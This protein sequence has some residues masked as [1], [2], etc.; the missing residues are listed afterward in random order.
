MSK[1][2]RFEINNNNFILING[3]CLEE[4]Y[5]IK[6]NSIDLI[7][8]DLPYE[9]TQNPWDNIIPFKPMWDN[10]KRILKDN[11]AVVLTASQPFTSKLVMSNLDWFKYDIIWEKTI[12][13]GQLNINKQ[14]LRV[15]E[16][17]LV[18]YNT[19]P[20]YN[21]QKTEG[22]PY[23]IKRNAKYN[24]ES[25][26]KQRPNEKNNDGYRHARSVITIANP[27]I[28]SGHP[29]QKPIALFE[30]I[31]NTYTNPGNL[32]LDCCMG[33][34]TTGFAC[35]NLNRSFIGIEKDEFYFSKAVKELKA[36]RLFVRL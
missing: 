26:G 24:N 15:H 31:I 20:I 5:K 35:V 2:I 22:V 18:F 33:S 29:T 9:I 34:G 1:E 28:K 19:Q 12:G 21:E 27:R 3:D 4:M 14:P 7:A 11:S 30:Y 17:V 23:K 16:S 13:S 6:D 32:V 8:V 36:Q 25:Y 10:F